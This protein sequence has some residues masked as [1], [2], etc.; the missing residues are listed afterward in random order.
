MASGIANNPILYGIYKAAGLLD[1]VA[2]GFAL[3]DIKVMGSGVNLRTSVADIMR[4]AS[5]GGSI[6]SGI[7]QMAMAGGNGGITGTG[8]LN[9]LGVNS[10]MSYVTRGTGQGLATTNGLAVSESGTMVGNAN[11]DD[12]QSK[13]LTDANDSGNQQ[14]ATAVDSSEET[15]LSTVDAHIVDIIDILKTIKDGN[16]VLSV[17]VEGTVS[18]SPSL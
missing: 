6:L 9:A 8:I 11:S 12:V 1:S 13:T 18:T 2:G 10:G 14:L 7:A 15:K 16:A 3:P 5:L 17:K 4:V